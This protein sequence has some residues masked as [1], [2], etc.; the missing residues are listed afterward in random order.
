MDSLGF[1]LR[2]EAHLQVLTKEVICTSEIEG[3]HLDFNTV[4][5]SIARR[6]GIEIGALAPTDRFVDDVVEMI[7][8]A[9]SHHKK[10]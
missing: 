1:K 5:S 2:D 8:D 7:V 4:R 3:K 10:N 6:L 9:T